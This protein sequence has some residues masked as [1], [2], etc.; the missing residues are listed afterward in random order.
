MKKYKEAVESFK[1]FVEVT[2]D[3]ADAWHNMAVGYMQLKKFDAALEPL[4]KS[5]ELRPDYG[6]AYYNL[7]ICYLNLKDD[8]SAREVYN[9]LK[10]ID[11]ALAQ[12]LK[13]YLK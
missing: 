12:K 8:F 5:I 4:R 11:S 3:N 6:T 9:K 13:K 2:P 10:G 1:K 7:A